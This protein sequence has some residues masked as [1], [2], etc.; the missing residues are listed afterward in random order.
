MSEQS[1]LQK[2]LE[3]SDKELSKLSKTYS[4]F[5]KTLT[6]ASGKEAREAFEATKKQI[7]DLEA[8]T[9]KYE[10]EL[11]SLS[12]QQ[13]KTTKQIKDTEDRTRYAK[14]Y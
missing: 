8:A 12:Q 1:T 7:V 13:A 14:I 11:N 3:D 10:K 5:N 4:N 2:V 6:A 9:K